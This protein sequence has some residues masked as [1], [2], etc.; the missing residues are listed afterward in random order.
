MIVIIPVEKFLKKKKKM[1]SL[2]DFIIINCTTIPK[3]RDLPNVLA[4]IR[5]DENGLRTDNITSLAY[6][7]DSVVFEETV[8]V[9]RKEAAL[10]SFFLGTG[11][12]IATMNIVATQLQFPD[13]NIYIL[14]EDESYNGYIDRYVAEI[15]ALIED[16]SN[17][18]IYTWNSVEMMKN[19]LETQLE[20]SISKFDKDEWFKNQGYNEFE[21][22]FIETL[23]DDE[24]DIY[25]DNV[26]ALNDLRAAETNKE[27]RYLFFKHAKYTKKQLKL[28]TKAVAD[29]SSNERK[30]KE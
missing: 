14:I 23:D 17:S 6:Q 2:K 20:K 11:F 4:D 9:R 16:E 22:P 1:F 18:I 13:K 3:V 15:S 25:L 21:D 27:I 8:P 5:T 19:T 24:Y 29:L 7:M 30:R 10:N 12:Q 28:L 26:S